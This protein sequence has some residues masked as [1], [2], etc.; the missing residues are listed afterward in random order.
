MKFCDRLEELGQKGMPICF[1]L[2]TAAKRINLRKLLIYSSQIRYHAYYRKLCE[3]NAVKCVTI[4]NKQRFSHVSKFP[5][6]SH[7]DKVF[8]P[9]EEFKD[10]RKE[11]RYWFS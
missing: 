10:A 2:A 7:A 5:M 4:Q 9:E 11:R 1:Q 8:S 3:A 6:R